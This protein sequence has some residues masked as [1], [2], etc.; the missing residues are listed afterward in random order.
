MSDSRPVRTPRNGSQPTATLAFLIVAGLVVGA[1]AVRMTLRSGPGRIVGASAPLQVAG[2]PD[3]LTSSAQESIAKREYEASENDRGLQ[4]P[5]RAHNLRTYFE[6]WGVRVED[7]TA[8]GSPELFRLK[9]IALGR[10]GR[11]KALKSGEVR[12]KGARVEVL[13]AEGVIEWYANGEAG[14]EHGY[15]IDRR[16]VGDGPLHIDVAFEGAGVSVAD[17]QAIVESAT[18]RHLDYGKLVVTD[19]AGR[20]IKARMSAISGDTVR[21]AI[22]DDQAVYP[23]VVDPLLTSTADTLLQAVG[24]IVAEAGDVNGDGYADVIVGYGPNIA[25]GNV[26]IFHGGPSGIPSGNISSA[27]AVLF[28]PASSVAGAGD[29]NGDGYSDVIVGSRFYSNG[30]T[31][32]GGAFIYLGGPG[33]I[34]SGALPSATL[35]SNRVNAFM[36]TSVAGAGDV[37]GDGY[38]DVVVGTPY[39]GGPDASGAAFVFN[40]GPTGIMNGNPD[41]AND[42]VRS[43]FENAL[44][45]SQVAGAGDVNG[46]GFA[47]VVVTSPRY[48][49]PGNADGAAFVFHG[50]PTGITSGIQTAADDTLQG[51]KSLSG[52][53]LLRSNSS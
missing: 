32:E 42:S 43:N 9:T 47:D 41:T 19:D 24:R 35:Q 4:A 49:I 53:A 20:E 13:R 36:G 27:S 2:T 3:L 1:A 11:A 39:F 14:L 30:E 23:I 48:G 38:A 31:N 12:P 37:N 51:T 6:P 8:D 22:E 45:G 34:S 52:T 28:V 26:Y 17:S 44:L 10:A 29:V 15:V 50:S 7:R 16:P 18:G 40:G 5:N 33:G 21:L 46:D 25:N